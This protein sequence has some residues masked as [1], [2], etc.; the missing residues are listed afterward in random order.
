M[1]E[2]A[3][4]PTPETPETPDRRGR[5]WLAI[6]V[7]LLL[8]VILVQAIFLARLTRSTGPQTAAD[9]SPA[10]RIAPV[11]QPARPARATVPTPTPPAQPPARTRPD[12]FDSFFQ[13]GHAGFDP[14]EEMSR[15]REQMDQ[16]FANAFGRF[17]MDPAF[18]QHSVDRAFMPQTDLRDDGDAYVVQMDIPGADESNISVTLNDRILTITGR[19]SSEV[20]EDADADQFLRVERRSGQ[21]ER[22]LTLPGPVDAEKMNAEYKGGVLTVRLPKL[23]KIPAQRQLTI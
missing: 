22:S 11:D 14:F 15:M 5:S 7:S 12:P 17:Q 10:M 9:T 13:G 19:T 16:M 21:F 23:E 3:S 18:Q 6:L 1:Q 4:N 2:H 8:L 20:R